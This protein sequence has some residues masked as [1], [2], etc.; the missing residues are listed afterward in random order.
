VTK[1]FTRTLLMQLVEDGKVSLDDPI[2]EYVTG[3][4]DGD[5]ATLRM[6]ANMTSGVKS[7]TR[8][9]RFTDVYFAKPETVFL[10]DD[11]IGI[12][13]EGSPLF[14]SG[15]E[16]DYSNAN[17]IPLGKVVEKV[18]GTSLESAYETMIF[19]PLGLTSTSWSGDSTVIPAPFPHGS[20]LRP[21]VHP[22][23]PPNPAE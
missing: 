5:P 1:T 7:Y 3:V 12:G 9:A 8:D 17:T 13:L 2:D 6:L 11:L 15:E 21:Q 22:P 20:T 23:P 4:P 10:T 16:F 19:E 14:E 18:T